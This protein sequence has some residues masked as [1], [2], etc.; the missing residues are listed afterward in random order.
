MRKKNGDGGINWPDFRLYYRTT[1]INTVTQKQKSRSMEQ[2][3]L[4]I[5]PNTYGHLNFDEG[6]NNIQRSK[7]YLSNEWCWEKMINQL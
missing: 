5:S 6:G 1:V 7:G 2:N 3:S 4:E